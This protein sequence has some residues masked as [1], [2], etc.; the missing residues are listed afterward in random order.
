MRWFPISVLVASALHLVWALGLSIDPASRYATAI[1]ALLLITDNTHLAAAVLVVVALLAL[2]GAFLP[3]WSRAI[4]V[5]MMLPQQV[6]LVMSSMAAGSAMASRSFADGVLRP[7]WF[8]TVDQVPVII[9]TVGYLIALSRVV[10]VEEGRP[11]GH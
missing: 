6:V 4:R 2:V 9:I 8:I 1:H 5:L 10:L 3:L 11:H 7:F